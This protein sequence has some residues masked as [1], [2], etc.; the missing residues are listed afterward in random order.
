MVFLKHTFILFSFLFLSNQALSYTPLDKTAA[1]VDDSV[2]LESELQKRLVRIANKQPNTRITEKIVRQVIDQL[3]LE[4]LQLRIARRANLRISDTEIDAAINNIKNNIA[5]E[6]ISFEEFL[7]SES[8]SE[9]ELR[10][11]LERSLKIQRVQKGR[12]SSRIQVTDR[13][14]DEFLQSKA[15]QEWLKIRYRLNHILLPI[16][17]KKETQTLKLAQQLIS[18]AQSQ[19]AP[20]E[21]LAAKFS[22]GPNADK[23]GDLG[24]R[25][26]DDLPALFIEQV[27]GLQVGQISQPFKSNAGIHILK[28]TQR[29]GADAVMVKRFKVRH[30]L[31][32]P[33]ELFTPEEAKQKIDK[34]YQ[35][36]V[37]GGD[38]FELAK[39]NTDDD[40]NKSEGGDL[41]WSLPGQF[42]PEFE[43]AMQNTPVNSFS[44]P[45]RTQFGWHILK[46]ED[47]KMED[48]FETVKRN[49]AAEMIRA[50][51]FQDE[52]QLWHQELREDAYVE[53]LI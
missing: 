33:T 43:Q 2:I 22:K 19:Q 4:E 28:L 7:I 39:A 46:V 13:E 10:Q 31:V 40:S 20:F 30:M 48:M 14:V 32:S 47:T 44:K 35:E 38:F 29:S 18:A 45:F 17:E 9:A 36:L 42:V 11:S 6:N 34:L 52:L 24:W 16:E 21:A 41:G 1:I 37:N 3:I 51:R 12:I 53:V 25:D 8:S 26:K 23:G 50:R 27:S 49:R 15:G 5:K